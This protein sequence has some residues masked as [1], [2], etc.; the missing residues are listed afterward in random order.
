MEVAARFEVA[1]VTSRR[2]RWHNGLVYGMETDT[3][4]ILANGIVT[5]N[6]RCVAIP[7]FP[8]RLGPAKAPAP[9]PEPSGD[10]SPKEVKLKDELAG[11]TK[12]IKGIRRQ[13]DLLPVGDPGRAAF[14][15]PIQRVHSKMVY[16]KAQLRKLEAERVK[17]TKLSPREVTLQAQLKGLADEIAAI[18]RERDLLLVGDPGRAAFKVPIQRVHSKMVYRKAQLRKLEAERL[19]GQVAPPLRKPKPKKP[20]G[21]ATYTREVQASRRR[22]P[23]NIETS[24]PDAVERQ[25]KRNALR[26]GDGNT[27]VNQW[28]DGGY[29]NIAKKLRQGTPLT[30]RENRMLAA[31]QKLTDQQTGFPTGTRFF[32]GCGQHT[33]QARPEARRHLREPR[34]G[35][36]EHPAQCGAVLC[37]R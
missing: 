19:G 2:N 8:D 4:L 15:V 35:V 7:V 14:K 28:H 26:Y 23:T 33:I 3:G 6:C 20:A 18:R 30:A 22:W 11:L 31:I 37:N 12:E 27:T 16:R 13:R 34:P 21:H 17:R 29:Y 24:A 5:H 32:P 10:L 36:M 25:W 9:A 1:T